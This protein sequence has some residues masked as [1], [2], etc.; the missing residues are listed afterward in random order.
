LFLSN[1]SKLNRLVTV[2]KLEMEQ[3]SAGASSPDPST[4]VILFTATFVGYKY[5]NNTAA[6]GKDPKAP[7]NAPTVTGGIGGK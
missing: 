4:D 2:E 1:V 3:H 6:P 7:T 5:S